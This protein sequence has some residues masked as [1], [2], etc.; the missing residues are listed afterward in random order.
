MH[1]VLRGIVWLMM[2]HKSK[3]FG[4]KQNLVSFSPDNTA[5]VRT[6]SRVSTSY[7]A[8]VLSAR[9]RTDPALYM[10]RRA[11]AS[12]LCMHLQN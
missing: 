2:T 10:R 9:C 12:A 5:S 4:L 1:A 3:Q 8:F 6:V 11:D 7:N